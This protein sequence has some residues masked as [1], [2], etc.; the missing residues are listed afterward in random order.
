MPNIKLRNPDIKFAAEYQAFVS[1]SIEVDGA[2]PWNNATRALANF[3]AYVQELN[4]ESAG[5]GLPE[6][7]PP[8]QTYFI[9]LD[10]TTVIGEMRYRPTIVEPYEDMNGHLGCNLRPAYRSKGYGHIAVQLV[11]DI[12]RA[13]GL[14]G[15][16]I[17]IEG[18]NRPSK[19]LV[20]KNGGQLVKT[21]EADEADGQSTY[22]YWI[23]FEIN[24]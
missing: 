6:G 5:I 9:V 2:Y 22:C 19:G 23:D 21:I 13:D 1:E 20:L 18:E 16:F 8:Q 10:E 17:P 4:E 14:T 24:E 12:V 11:L 7:V 3:A 15:V